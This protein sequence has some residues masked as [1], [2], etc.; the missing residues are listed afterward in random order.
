MISQKVIATAQENGYKFFVN[1]FGHRKLA[2]I[3]DLSGKHISWTSNT[4]KAALTAI[5]ALV[6]Q[7]ELEAASNEAIATEAIEVI[8]DLLPPVAD[9][10]PIVAE[11]AYLEL[12]PVAPD[13]RRFYERTSYMGIG[14]EVCCG[15][16]RYGYALAELLDRPIEIDYTL[17]RQ[18]ME[19]ALDRDCDR[20]VNFTMS[21]PLGCAALI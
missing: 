2:E 5:N 15:D 6:K 21:A 11:Q 19:Q 14:I 9:I 4:S 16:E 10:D 1:G 20:A 13:R 18:R 8:A 3:T 17:E 12:L 7:R